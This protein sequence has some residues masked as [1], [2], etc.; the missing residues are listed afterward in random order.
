MRAAVVREFNQDLSLETVDDPACPDTGVVPGLRP[1]SASEDKKNKSCSIRFTAVRSIGIS[2]AY[3]LAGSTVVKSRARVKNLFMSSFLF[4]HK[5]SDQRLY[6]EC[7]QRYESTCWS[8]G[9][10]RR[11]QHLRKDDQFFIGPP[12]DC[13]LKPVCLW[14]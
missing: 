10:L 11:K 12:A 9:H 14:H 13:S 6:L 5:G 8:N 1:F 4:P 2:C 7:E 3:T